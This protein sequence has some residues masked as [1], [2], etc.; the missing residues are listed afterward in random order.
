MRLSLCRADSPDDVHKDN[1]SGGMWY[2]LTVPA[3]SDDPPLND[4]WHNTTFISYLELAVR[5][6]G[7]PGLERCSEH[8]WPL[9]LLLG[10]PAGEG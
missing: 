8:D 7:F 6:G 3:V 2:N 10:G 1:V 9:C 4:E 5:W